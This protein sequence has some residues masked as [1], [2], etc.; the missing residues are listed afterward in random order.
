MI[1]ATQAEMAIDRLIVA[2]WTGRD[3]AT[4]EHHIEELA[5][6]GVAP[7]SQV[8]LFYRV[9]A[10]LLTQ[11]PCIEVLGDH[12]SGEAE[13][14]LVQR[15]ERC[16]LGLASDHTD[17]ALEAQSVAASKQVCAKPCADELW[18]F[19]EVEGH[20]DALELRSWI[21]S[22]QGDWT[23]YQE[24]A[25][26][27]IRPLGALRTAGG[28]SDGAAMLCGT[29]GAIGG[30]RPATRFRATLTDPVLSREIALE[31]TT[32]TLPVIS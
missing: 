8:P 20:L 16:W 30:V 27:A 24:G 18:D 11:E 4:V 12:T 15:D 17:R 7:P 31:Y 10:S 21:A 3:A 32:A 5:A 28:L 22:G 29:L 14:L 9:A 25:L 23:L 6:L 13:P 19:A 1:G 26:A 2:G